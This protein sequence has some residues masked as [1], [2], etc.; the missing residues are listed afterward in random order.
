MTVLIPIFPL[1]LV[2][3]PG[4]ALNL[5]IFEPRYRQLIADTEKTGA[6]FGV[7][8]VIDKRLP[9]LGTLVELVEVTTRHADGRLDIKTRGVKLFQIEEIIK[10][11]PGKLYSGARVI[12]P[13]NVM[14]GEAKELRA[15]LKLVRELH[16]CLQVEKDFS[17]PDNKLTAYDLAHHAGL[18]AA[19]EYELLGLREERERQAYLQR[20]LEKI[21]PVVRDMGKLRERI[22]LN[23]H[24]KHLPGIDV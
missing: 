4:E 19:Q 3:Y 16:A 21:L 10:Q 6:P 15:L 7:P 2:V 20:H 23:G 22:Q 17:K 12:F 13:P 8:A 5:H 14:R 24:F 1:E 18:S 11:I 9:G